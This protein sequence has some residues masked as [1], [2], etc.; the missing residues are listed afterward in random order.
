MSTN[1]GSQAMTRAADAPR[2]MVVFAREVKALGPRLVRASGGK[3]DPERLGQLVVYTVQRTPALAAAI[4]TDKGRRS[5]LDATMDAATLG[6]MPTGK[7]GGGYMIPFKRTDKRTGEQWTDVVFV[8]D[9]RALTCAVERGFGHGWR[10]RA[11]IVC[12]NDKATIQPGGLRPFLEHE[13]DVN[14]T[15]ETRGALVG[16]YVVATPPDDGERLWRYLSAWEI[17]TKHEARSRGAGN[18][19]SPWQTDRDTM[20]KKTALRVFASEYLDAQGDV[21][22]FLAAADRETEH[23]DTPEA[24]ALTAD[25]D[26]LDVTPDAEA[27][28]E[29]PPSRMAGL[30]GRVAQAAPAAPSTPPE[31]PAA[32][33]TSAPSTPPPVPRQMAGEHPAV[34][35]QGTLGLPVGSDAAKPRPEPDPRRDTHPDWPAPACVECQSNEHVRRATRASKYGDFECVGPQHPD[36]VRFFRATD[37]ETGKVAELRGKLNAEED[38]I[39]MDALASQGVP[40]DVRLWTGGHAARASLLAQEM[41]SNRRPTAPATD[42]APHPA[43]G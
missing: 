18:A 6:L 37:A 39:L 29:P 8:P 9:Y 22:R 41:L 20:F 23:G 12:E 15:P 34:G 24:A 21:Q 3:V 43:E 32:A 2:P 26:L 35:G 13:Y 33:T 7:H 30:A 10:V 11:E 28:A 5:V 16:A 31:P 36:E 38:E 27:P 4:L 19:D 42:D 17:T 40:G 1:G 14:G 25:V